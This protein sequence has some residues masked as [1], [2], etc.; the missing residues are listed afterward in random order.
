[1]CC[2][3]A[4]DPAVAE[5]CFAAAADSVVAEGREEEVAAT[6]CLRKGDGP[7]AWVV[8]IVLSGQDYWQIP[9]SKRAARGVGW[10][11]GVRGEV[12]ERGCGHEWRH[13]LPPTPHAPL[14]AFHALPILPSDPPLAAPLHML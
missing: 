14:S 8:L 10:G 6:E 2:A 4:A 11:G 13:T 9:T 5:V 12:A 3:V 1:M 7:K